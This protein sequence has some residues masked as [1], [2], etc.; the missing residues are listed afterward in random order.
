MAKGI[1]RL[2]ADLALSYSELA[3]LLGMTLPQLLYY[4][5]F[6]PDIPLFHVQEASDRL[7]ISIGKIQDGS[8]DVDT[9]RAHFSG[10]TSALPKKY[11]NHAHS[12]TR[13]V[14]S[15][16]RFA[17]L[18]LHP[19]AVRNIAKELQLPPGLGGRLEEDINVEAVN[20][21]FER[22]A[23]YGL[24][25]DDFY[26]LG[27]MNASLFLQSRFGDLLKPHQGKAR[28][29]EALFA[30][31]GGFI[32]LVDQ[33]FD[34]RL[35]DLNSRRAVIQMSSKEWA[36]EYFKCRN[37]GGIQFAYNSLGFTSGLGVS[38]NGR[39]CTSILKDSFARGG[40][41]NLFEVNFN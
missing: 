32:E 36:R 15:A 31:Q 8:Y 29:W 38:Y 18:K 25:F 17:S 26:R 2:K 23:E 10:Q 11:L 12:R 16:L 20:T 34:Y 3:D 24:G 4:G 40:T 35:L 21:L 41:H 9:L 27:Q 7:N 19:A 33:N 37:Y 28:F 22:I 13:T 30:S 14:Y 1:W 6:S 39:P 5:H